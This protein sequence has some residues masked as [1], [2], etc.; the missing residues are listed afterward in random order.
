MEENSEKRHTS[1]LIPYYF[2]DR[3]LYVFL[4]RRSADAPRNPN[5]LGGFGGGVEGEENN[6][7]AL[8]REMQ[9][10]L[11]YTPINYSLLGTFETNHSISN[12][13]IEEVN[14]NFEKNVI[15][16]EGKGGEWHKA[17]NAIERNDISLNTKK[18]I[19]GMIAKLQK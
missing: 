6:E 10:E 18:V 8:L 4:Q 16:H 19:E 1:T 2:K 9:E 14:E 13:Y 11:E 17:I 5:S 12:Y 3:E 15:V 7:E